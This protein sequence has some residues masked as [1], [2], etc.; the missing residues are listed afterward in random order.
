M[1]MGSDVDRDRARHRMD[2]DTIH[3]DPPWTDD[4]VRMRISEL[5]TRA[6]VSVATTKF[7]LR[8]GLLEPGAATAVNQATYGEEHVH[9][10]SLIR[11]LREVAGLDLKAIRRV[12]AAIDDERI[13]RH[14]LLG[15]AQ[16][17]LAGP[18]IDPVAESGAARTR[19]DVDTF[20]DGLG[21]DVRPDAPARAMLASALGALRRLG[22]DVGP[23]VFGR[24]AE[25]A[26]AMAAWEVGALPADGSRAAIV[27]GLVVGTLIYGRAFDALRRLAHEHHSAVHGRKPRPARPRAAA[28]SPAGRAASRATRRRRASGS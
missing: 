27:E 15:I 17:T 21:W 5:A 13:G 3:S 26:D 24:Y 19:A 1:S 8:E 7:Y 28:R 20:I 18:G 12:V 10:L 23:D 22:R 14:E 6:G 25:A 9:R 11:V 16:G 4:E 2:S